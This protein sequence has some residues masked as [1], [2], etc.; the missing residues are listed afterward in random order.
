MMGAAAGNCLILG[1]TIKFRKI[2]NYRP[3]GFVFRKI[4]VFDT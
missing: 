3:A 4:V 1:E 2:K